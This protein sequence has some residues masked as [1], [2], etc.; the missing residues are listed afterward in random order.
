MLIKLRILAPAAAGTLIGLG[1]SGLAA[2]ASIPTSVKVQ[3]PAP[4]L[5]QTT[6]FGS[7]TSGWNSSTTAAPTTGSQTSLSFPTATLPAGS[8]VSVL[9][10]DWVGIK[11]SVTNAVSSTSW[12][13]YGSATN[14]TN[15]TSSS[16]TIPASDIYIPNGAYGSKGSF[17]SGG[18]GSYSTSVPGLPGGTVNAGALA[19]TSAALWAGMSAASVHTLAFQPELKV[20]AGTPA[21]SYTGTITLT[22][23]LQ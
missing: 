2:A 5:T 17:V 11:V 12:E 14:L 19:T 7:A 16:D 18:V 4:T 1:L 6:V 20:P 23:Q 9:A 13:V 8:G 15:S 22:A 10:S 3:Q 21:G